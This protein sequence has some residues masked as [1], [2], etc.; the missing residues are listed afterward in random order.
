[1]RI[2]FS[3]SLEAPAIVTIGFRVSLARALSSA[4]AFSGWNAAAFGNCIILRPMHVHLWV[5]GRSRMLPSLN[6]LSVIGQTNVKI[7][8]QQSLS[9]TPGGWRTFDVPPEHVTPRA[10]TA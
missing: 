10:V 6:M 9:Y 7:C 8:A 3:C 4:V 2:S 1:M 5:R